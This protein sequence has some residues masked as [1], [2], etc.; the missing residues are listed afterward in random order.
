[1]STKSFLFQFS[2][3]PEEHP[4]VIQEG[5]EAALMAVAFGQSV[6]L[7]FR[8]EGGELLH[9]DRETPVPGLQELLELATD[10]FVEANTIH[11]PA[12]V[13]TVDAIECE[14]L[15]RDHAVV[16]QF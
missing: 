9:R 4:I 10:V 1:M 14:T 8:G 16:M 12:P 13:N 7:L 5:V 11:V 6:T 3:G 15:I 2:H